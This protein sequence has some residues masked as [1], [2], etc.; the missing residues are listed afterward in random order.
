MDGV[1]RYLQL[2]G[3]EVKW[4]VLVFK[5]MA[6]M[7]AA[8]W[9]ASVVQSMPCLQEDECIVVCGAHVGCFC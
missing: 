6:G 2:M 8:F 7:K 1:C 3:F 5:L 9:R 4:E